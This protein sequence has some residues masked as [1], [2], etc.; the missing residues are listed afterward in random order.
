MKSSNLPSRGRCPAALPGVTALA[1]ALL[2]VGPATSAWALASSWSVGHKAQARLVAGRAAPSDGGA[3]LAFI[4]IELAPGWKTYW[5]SPGDAGLPPEF[6][7]SKSANLAKAD[8]K[9]PAPKHFVDKSGHTLGYEGRL[10]L[11]VTLTPQAADRPVSLAVDVHYGIC[12]EICVPIEANLA[13]DIP[14]G[15]AALAPAAALM[16][17][18]RVPRPQDKVLADD[19]V[20]VRAESQLE[21]AAPKI[22]VAA[23]FP[24]NPSEAAVFLEAAGGQFLPVPAEVGEGADGSKVFEAALWEGFDL[25]ALRGKMVTV[26]LVGEVGASYATFAI[27]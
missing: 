18:D 21:G 3:L 6:D 10:F 26:T 23:K 16:A 8:V 5:R 14:A 22:V 4:E 15:E 13:L 9:F 12:K 17:L 25:A 20:L 11:P 24:G 1:I 19:P 27:P 2:A 7:W